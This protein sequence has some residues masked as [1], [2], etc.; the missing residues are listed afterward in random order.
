M[1]RWSHREVEGLANRPGV[2]LIRSSFLLLFHDMDGNLPSPNDCYVVGPRPEEMDWGWLCLVR[3]Y[4]LLS[5]LC[6]H[7]SIHRAESKHCSVC[8]FLEDG[9]PCQACDR[10]APRTLFYQMLAP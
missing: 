4:V 9:L 3:G 1:H 7:T 5:L 2:D 6:T 8:R 10:N